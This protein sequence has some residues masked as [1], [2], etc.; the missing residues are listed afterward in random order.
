MKKLSKILIVLMLAT[1]SL[2]G[3]GFSKP[4]EAQLSGC[5]DFNGDVRPEI[6]TR[7]ECEALGF[8][9]LG[10]SDTNPNIPPPSDPAGD[11]GGE[12]AEEDPE[13]HC[14]LFGSDSSVMACL[15]D[16]LN[17]IG[18]WLMET[19]AFITAMAAVILN[20]VV[21]YTVVK[22]AQNFSFISEPV[23]VAWGLVRDIANMGFIFMLL[24][25]S[26]MTI[27]GRERDARGLVVKMVVAAILVNFSL[28]FTKVIIDIANILALTFYSAIVPASALNSG[29][30]LAAGISNGLVSAVQAQSL[31]HVSGEL[32]TDGSLATYL[33]S[34]VVLLVITFVFA[35]A[36]MLFIVRYVA[37]VFVMIL[38]PLMLLAGVFP[39]LKKYRE[40]WWNTLT[41]QAFFAP[42]F[43][44]LMWITLTLVN[45]LS[46]VMENPTGTFADALSTDGFSAGVVP[47]LIKFALV[48]SFTVAT[49]IISKM[50]SAN[51]G[52]HIASV[53]KW[54]MGAAGGAVFGGAGLVGRQT[55]GRSAANT[56]NNQ[57]LLDRSKEQN[58]SG[59][60]ARLQ[61]AAARKTSGFSFDARSTGVTGPLEAGKSSGVGGFAKYK[62]DKAEA[63]K[64]VADSLKPSDEV[65]DQAEQDLNKIKA[66]DI[67][68]EG[69]S[70]QHKQAVENR[71]RAVRLQNENAEKAEKEY[72]NYQDDIRGGKIKVNTE[73]LKSLKEE[74]EKQR[75]NAQSLEAKATAILSKEG[76]QQSLSSD[77]QAQVD[78]LKGVSEEEAK[79]RLKKENP[80]YWTD[81]R[82]KSE[83]G[84]KAI[85]ESKVKSAGELRKEAYAQTMENSILAKIGGYNRAAAATIRKSKSNK[86]KLAEAAAAFSKETSGDEE[87]KSPTP[88]TEAPPTGGGASHGTSTSSTPPT[89]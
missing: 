14:G 11:T 18:Y 10:S 88:A 17:Y 87:S 9:W 16:G 47:V 2:V 25:A 59:R 70:I 34:T 22:M 21:Y 67:T 13:K 73:K 80:G 84:R 76:Y 33:L 42:I 79:K 32:G 36:A 31:W 56:L 64:K 43:F 50:V 44:A 74:A 65:I 63:A 62:K 37:L 6:A 85:E 3:I 57:K 38:S 40:Q 72:S 81:A 52:G 53:G 49:I 20:G 8:T 26:I 46:G 60:I 12:A 15:E 23:N 58:M 61:L 68:T 51:A 75:K 83:E 30:L 77:A 45:N 35:A 89:P 55:L 39:F 4:V 5:V 78:S 41:S 66:T 54:A 1:T 19:M 48:I 86:D 69:F 71:E 27:I 29:D 82:I 28:F 24:F 7:A